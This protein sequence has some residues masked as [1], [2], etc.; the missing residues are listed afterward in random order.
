MSTARTDGS[1]GHSQNLHREAFLLSLC[2]DTYSTAERGEF[3]LELV[4]CSGHE[5]IHQQ[6]ITE[7]I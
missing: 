7:S 1:W 6:G 2:E 3:F 5:T 4:L